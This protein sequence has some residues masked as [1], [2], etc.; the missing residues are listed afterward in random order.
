MQV[1]A[2]FFPHW[3]MSDLSLSWLA[4]S[5]MLD[6]NE[7]SRKGMAFHC[8]PVLK[9]SRQ[10][11]V[12]KEFNWTRDSKDLHISFTKWGRLKDFHFFAGK[13]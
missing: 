13:F 12:S 9:C 10:T 8:C 5:K 3:L 2:V 7:V 1:I 4:T 6:T 11:F